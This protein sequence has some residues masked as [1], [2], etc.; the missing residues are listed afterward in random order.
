MDLA[1]ASSAACSRPASSIAPHSGLPVAALERKPDSTLA[2][3]GAV[4]CLVTDGKVAQ[5]TAFVRAHL[6][7]YPDHVNAR[8]TL[9]DLLAR[10]GQTEEAQE[11]L[12]E[13]ITQRP[14]IASAYLVLAGT[15]PDDAGRASRPSSRGRAA[16]PQDPQIGMRLA[17]EYE[18]AGRYDDAIRLYDD[19]VKANPR[20]FQAV[21]SLASLLLDQRKDEDSHKRALDLA[22][23]FATAKIPAYLDT[24]GWAHYVNGDYDSAVRFLE[25][26][27]AYTEKPHPLVRYHLGMAYMASDNAVGARR[28]LEKALEE[29]R[30]GSQGNEESKAALAKLDART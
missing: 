5:A 29:T 30:P 16:A 4:R 9:A 25:L 28:E 11:I 6:E 15:Y 10:Q 8:V 24:L 1:I 14:E 7:R 21:N 20:M 26:A 27:V 22:Q 12:N 3:Q 19:L 18:R 13:V 2:F 23:V 17:A